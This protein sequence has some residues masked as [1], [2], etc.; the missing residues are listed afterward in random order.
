M[1]EP[2]VS[3]I[4]VS[5]NSALHIEQA[6]KSVLEQDYPNIEHIIVDGGSTD[7]TLDVIKKYED[8]IAKYVSEPDRG[9]TDAINKGVKMA[10]GDI[11]ALLNSDDYYVDN[12]V[13]R[14][15]VETFKQ[16][17]D[18]KMVYGILNY[19]DPNTGE[20]IMLWGRDTD[21]SEIR[22]RMYLPT[23]TIFSRGEIWDRVGPFSESYNYA[24]DYEW[25]IR[26]LKITRLYFLNHTITCMRDMG[27]SGQNYREALAETA[28]ALKQNGYYLDYVKTLVRNIIK[29]VLIELGLKD[30]VYR[31][32]ARNVSPKDF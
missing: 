8:K 31:I 25:A 11:I 13:I 30:I 21:P 26:A 2:L 16:S 17:E 7:G 19:V 27:R 18:I 28:R 5:Y 6:I 22:K 14:R 4:T 29:T 23:P 10:S 9:P 20:S 3:I 24:D 32:W 12:S 1:R 15:V